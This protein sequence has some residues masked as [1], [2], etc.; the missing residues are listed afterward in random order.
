MFNFTGKKRV[1]NF[2]RIIQNAPKSSKMAQEEPQDW[3]RRTTR[4][5]RTDK[6]SFEQPYVS[7]FFPPPLPLDPFFKRLLN[8]NYGISY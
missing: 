6:K 4:D 5:G 1:L 2:E 3:P 7:L 8:N